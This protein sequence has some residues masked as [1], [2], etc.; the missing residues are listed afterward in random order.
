M[1]SR[2]SPQKY[3]RTRVRAACTF[4][5]A[6][7]IENLND[8]YYNTC[9][10]V[11][12]CVFKVRYSRYCAFHAGNS[13]VMEGLRP[14]RLI[15]THRRTIIIGYRTSSLFGFLQ[16]RM[17]GK[18]IRIILVFRCA[19][20]CVCAICV[21]REWVA[22]NRVPHNSI[23]SM[24]SKGDATGPR[25]T[26]VPKMTHRR[27]VMIIVFTF[28]FLIHFPSQAFGRRR[29][30]SRKRGGYFPSSIF[31]H[32]ALPSPISPGP[33]CQ[34]SLVR[35]LPSEHPRKGRGCLIWG[36]TRASKW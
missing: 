18:E 19:F 5:R 35:S 32:G 33:D 25:G 20:K 22:H 14:T 23:A 15:L 13:F 24:I 6:W 31:P 28:Y 17:R 9:V 1:F 11:C 3:T 2:Q 8:S 21:S 7:N 29:A 12:V 26:T 10:C 30:I 16:K 4:K 34:V 27:G 36:E